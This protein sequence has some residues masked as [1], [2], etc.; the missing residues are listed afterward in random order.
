MILIVAAASAAMMGA[1]PPSALANVAGGLWEIIGTP[2]TK[3]P[4][5][6][7]VGDVAALAEFEHRTSHCTRSV[8]NDRGMSTLIS[9]KCGDAGFGQSTIEVI[10]PRSLKIS[11]QGISDQLPYNYVLQAHRVGDCT[12]GAAKTPPITHH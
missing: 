6:E 5:R 9:Y 10:T 2:R 3:E 7:C 12:S 11:T 4:I 8:V 1:A